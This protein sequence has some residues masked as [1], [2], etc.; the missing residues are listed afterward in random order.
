MVQKQKYQFTK[1]DK[2]KNML[3]DAIIAALLAYIAQPFW[4]TVSF[5]EVVAT[6]GLTFWGAFVAI[7]DLEEWIRERK[8]DK[9]V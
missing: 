3:K 8:E 9:N 5:W 2:G 1:P 6:Y 7:V 4:I